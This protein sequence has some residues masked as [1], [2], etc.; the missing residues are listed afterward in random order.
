[1][2]KA[3]LVGMATTAWKPSAREE[4]TRLLL[5]LGWGRRQLNNLEKHLL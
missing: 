3:G 5:R 1:M 4:D 2:G